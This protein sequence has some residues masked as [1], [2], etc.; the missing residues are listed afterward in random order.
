MSIP[1][2][3]TKIGRVIVSDVKEDGR[4]SRPF[5]FRV[6]T[7]DLDGD[8]RLVEFRRHYDVAQAHAA[9]ALTITQLKSLRRDAKKRK[10]A[11]P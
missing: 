9:R 1:P 5:F 6:T 11:K 3:G 8:P 7:L 4:Y 2:E 10:R